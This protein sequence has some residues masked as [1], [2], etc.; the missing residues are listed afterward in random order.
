V[1]VDADYPLTDEKDCASTDEALIA[2]IQAGETE[3]LGDLFIKHAQGVRRLLISIM[4]TSRDLDDLA[5]E[6]FLAVH[7]SVLSFKGQSKFST[8]LH[9]ITVN[10]ALSA[11]RRPRRLTAVL[12]EDLDA[13]PD[14]HDLESEVSGREMVRRL[15]AVLSTM[16]HK[17]RVAFVLFEIEGRSIEE[18]AELTGVPVPAA[19]SRIFFARRELFQKA[20]A[21]AYL[22]PLLKELRP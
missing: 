14:P 3:A 10:T 5:Q 8:W 6:V 12:Q 22:A 15:Y 11:L 16:P 21:D 4:G 20:K 2:R 9:R 19:K 1:R 17:R 18:T 7:R 13:R